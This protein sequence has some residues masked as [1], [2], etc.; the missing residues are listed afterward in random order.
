MC[1]LRWFSYG[2]DQHTGIR[3]PLDQCICAQFLDIIRVTAVR[4]DGQ[5]RLGF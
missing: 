3:S 2:D 1:K 5:A 4:D